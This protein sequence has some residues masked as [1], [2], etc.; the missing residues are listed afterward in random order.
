MKFFDFKT[1]QDGKSFLSEKEVNT[2]ILNFGDSRSRSDS[3][4]SEEEVFKVVEWANWVRMQQSMLDMVMENKIDIDINEEG[5]VLFS[6][7]KD[8]PEWP[9]WPEKEV[10]NA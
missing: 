3:S 4:F 6:I 7:K 5:E 1:N 2:V 10:P 8:T 9:E